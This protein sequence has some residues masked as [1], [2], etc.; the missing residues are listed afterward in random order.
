MKK[1]TYK[2]CYRKHAARGLCKAHHR[3]LMKYGEARNLKEAGNEYIEFEDYYKMVVFDKRRKQ[4]E[5]DI[6]ISKEDYNKCKTKRWFFGGQYVKEATSKHCL[7]LHRFIFD[8]IPEN[9]VVDHVNRNKLDNR[10]DNLRIVTRSEN[11]K[12]K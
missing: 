5:F 9:L 12:N 7:Y 8:Y 11:N 3:H 10:R 1:C 2:D 4:L 6:F